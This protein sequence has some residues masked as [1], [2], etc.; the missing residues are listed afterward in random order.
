[1][2]G[3]AR[4]WAIS[5]QKLANQQILGNAAPG[6]PKPHFRRFFN[7]EKYTE[8]SEGLFHRELI[9]ARPSRYISGVTAYETQPSSIRPVVQSLRRTWIWA[10]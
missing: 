2:S 3:F 10:S 1:M 6:R 8:R 4:F 9:T 5:A 7:G